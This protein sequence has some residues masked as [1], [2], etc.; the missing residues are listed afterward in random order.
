LDALLEH[1]ERFASDL[2]SGRQAQSVFTFLSGSVEPLPSY[3]GS[4]R[5]VMKYM[6]IFIMLDAAI[7]GVDSSV[8]WWDCKI[9]E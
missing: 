4:I 8:F 1:G 5:I 2:L 9:V 6:M 7:S 3:A